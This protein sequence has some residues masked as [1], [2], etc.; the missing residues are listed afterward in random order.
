MDKDIFE[1]LERI[2][3]TEDPR[4]LLIDFVHILPYCLDH[5]SEVISYIRQQNIEQKIGYL[6][7]VT[8]AVEGFSFL[9]P[10]AEALYNN[11]EQK[12]PLTSKISEKWK[13][14]YDSLNPEPYSTRWN[15]YSRT[16]PDELKELI[17]LYG[18]A[19][20]TRKRRIA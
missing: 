20:E 8:S 6:F 5:N 19:G 11:P 2:K 17:V 4:H 9:K 16:L 15:M 14:Y 18:I 13:K 12:V 10:M 3:I 7:D 1:R